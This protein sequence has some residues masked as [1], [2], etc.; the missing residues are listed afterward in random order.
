M[1][2]RSALRHFLDGWRVQKR[3]IH[4]L[5][6]RELHTRFG[7]DNI[8]FLWIMVEPLLFAGA[9]GALWTV[10]KGPQSH[11]MGIV[12]F[13]ASGYIPLT[14]MRHSFSKAANVFVAN[15]SLLYHR[16]IKITDFIFVRILIEAIGSMMAYVFLMLA[17][18]NFGLFPIPA[19]PAMLIAGW[20][21]YVLFV[22]SFCM[23]IAPLSEM[24]E[25]V[26]KFLPVSTYIAIPLSGTFNMASWLTPEARSYLLWSP[27]VSGME[28]M[29]YGLFGSV[30]TPYYD[31]SRSVGISLV[32]LLIGLSLSRH[33]R[34]ILVV[35]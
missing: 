32:F 29:R 15:G 3:V 7:R 9:V 28:M 2:A 12:A 27:L 13:V 34:R 11:G 18:Y 30:V 23:I 19:N 1:R 6:I 17:L 22:L 25:V 16:Q 35:Q 10:V 31:V 21:I 8:G 26:E 33:V 14:F 20:S 24:S 5:M 4:A